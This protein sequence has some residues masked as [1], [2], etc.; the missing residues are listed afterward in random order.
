MANEQ[1]D[2]REL[3][4]LRLQAR[5]ARAIQT[6]E[7]HQKSL[8]QEVS[9]RKKRLRRVM[10]AIQ[11]REQMGTLP[12]EGIEGVSISEADD[13]LIYDPLRGL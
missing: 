11:Q 2:R 10:L 1:S 8:V 13:R 3:E 4:A 9:E 5:A 7:G 12:L 6:L